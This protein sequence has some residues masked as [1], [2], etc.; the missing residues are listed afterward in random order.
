MTETNIAP[1]LV[2]ILLLSLVASSGPAVGTAVVSHDGGAPHHGS[3]DSDANLTSS[4]VHW[5]GQQLYLQGNASGGSFDLHEVDGSGNSESIGEFVE[6]VR[7][8]DNAVTVFDS[9]SVE[10]GEY[11]L[12]ADDDQLVRTNEQGVQVGTEDPADSGAFAETAITIAEQVS[13]SRPRP[14]RRPCASRSSSP[15][16][17]TVGSTTWRSG[18][19]GS[20]PRTCSKSSA[21]RK[22][23]TAR[24][25][26]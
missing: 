7:L 10:P 24:G 6:T 11:V 9:S 18:P 20:T 13:T 12:V 25:L 3:Y 15:S 14:R 19:E 22:P 16:I 1:T 4:A 21:E 23:T 8:D 17:R 5:Q 26:R 2:S